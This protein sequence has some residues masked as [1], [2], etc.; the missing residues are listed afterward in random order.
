M[1]FRPPRTLPILTL[2]H[3]V[4]VKNSQAALQLL[5]S[6]QK[7]ESGDE[8]YRIDVVDEAHS[9]PTETQLKQMAS[10]LDSPTPY[11][12]LMFND[13]GTGESQ[14]TN[15]HDALK[16]IDTAKEFAA[17]K[18][19]LRTPI[20]VDWERGKAAIGQPTLQSIE[21]LINERIK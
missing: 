13:A 9:Q 5:Q 2:F 21:K 11:K 19:I 10:F 8:K 3:N 6:K 20:L 14:V 4:R 18:P 1:S 17:D 16:Y 7:T 12:D 15:V